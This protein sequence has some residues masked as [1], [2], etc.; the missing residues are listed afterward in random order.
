MATL[1]MMGAF[2]ALILLGFSMSVAMGASALLGLWLL[3]VPLQT[4]A[5]LMIE[6][7][8]SIAFL[9]V[10][11]FILSANLLSEMR[12][13]D[14]IF[15]VANHATGRLPG[16]LAQVNVVSTVLFSG[17]SGSALADI[18][19]MGAILVRAMARM[20]YRPEFAAALS[21]VASI[22]TPM[23]PPS[24]MMIIYAVNMNT[25]IAALFVAGIVPG[26][27]FAVAL[28]LTILAMA[29]TGRETFPV[30][31]RSSRREVLRDT[32]IGLPAIAT[33]VF[34]LGG[35]VMGY[36]TPTEAALVAVFYALLLG[37]VYGEATW[38]RIARAMLSTCM[39]T[40]VIMLLTA[41]GGVM[42]YV[43]ISSRSAET[44]AGLLLSIS[45]HPVFILLAVNLILLLMGMLMETVPSMLISI[46]MLGPIALAAGV[47]P[48]HFGVIL[49]FNLLVG[50]IT[51]PS[52]IGIFT[53]C[54]VTGLSP[55]RVFRETFPFYVAMVGVLALITFVPVLSLW[56]PGLLIS[57]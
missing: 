24:V 29:L 23:I 28:I 10:P 53:I 4:A 49:V 3:G 46:P 18:G 41:L 7:L 55:D 15:R 57:R 30:P 48:V 20:G 27:L 21:A 52:G 9:A 22:I 42:A 56:L 8:R 25:S 6:E 34:V 19:G 39:S 17:A 2:I 43:V 11:F 47:D 12:V 38:P 50:I 26:L 14:R 44:V 32:I 45:D 37:L 5:R 54:A 31:E 1:V 40:S 36:T 33:P 35:I 13:S 16:G 51:P